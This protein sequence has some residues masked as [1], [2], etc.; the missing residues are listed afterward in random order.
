MQGEERHEQT[1]GYLDI[2]VALANQNWA[3]GAALSPS[4]YWD[5]ALSLAMLVNPPGSTWN[6]G[7]WSLDNVW[8]P[9]VVQST[10]GGT[11][12]AWGSPGRKAGEGARF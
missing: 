8:G 9:A 10:V 3:M 7:V 1:V 12:A 11:S 2:T 6:N 4:V 5:S